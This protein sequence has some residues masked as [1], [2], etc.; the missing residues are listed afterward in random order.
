MLEGWLRKTH[1]KFGA[2]IIN[3]SI[4]LYFGLICSTS[5]DT[6]CVEVKCPY[7]IRDTVVSDAVDCLSK[8]ENGKPQFKHNHPYYS[9][10]Q[11]QL[12][13][14]NHDFVDFVVWTPFDIFIERVQQ[15]TLFIQTNLVKAQE[16]YV[17]VILPEL[18]A[19]FYTCKE[20]DDNLYCYCRVKFNDETLVL[21]CTNSNCV[22]K[23]FHLS[24]CGLSRKPNLKTWACPDC[25]KLK[26]VSA[27]GAKQ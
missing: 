21:V 26:K 4:L 10:V 8:T 15:D 2:C 5:H 3:W 12:A 23:R 18:L 11:L 25:R 20:S 22:F 9:Q 6:G 1:A 16:L 24:C 7:S 27:A 14:T 17:T 13:L 19:R